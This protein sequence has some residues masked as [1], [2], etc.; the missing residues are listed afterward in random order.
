LP[1]E[2]Y[3]KF[4]GCVGTSKETIMPVFLSHRTADDHVAQ[5]IAN[6][7][8]SYHK[9]F[10]YIDNFDPHT[11]TTTQVTSLILERI[12]TCTH[13]LALIT[14]NTIGSWWVPFEV[15]VARQANRRI[16]SVDTSTQTLPEYLTEWPVLVGDSA[17]DAFAELYHED[18]AARPLHEK[19]A[20]AQRTIGSADEFHRRLKAQ[21]GQK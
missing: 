7:L 9:I 14:N 2:R 18:K 13:I 15:G 20:A 17:I 19:R 16:A 21:L 6:R 12:N 4:A 10:C 1:Y 8:M 5:A 3:E 11:K